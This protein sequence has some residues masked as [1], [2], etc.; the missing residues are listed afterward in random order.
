MDDPINASQAGW[1]REI[2]EITS[3]RQ[4]NEGRGGLF[5]SINS[6]RIMIS[7]RGTGGEGNRSD[8]R[9]AESFPYKENCGYIYK[10]T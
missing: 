8:S 10:S 4:F 5:L 6:T 1:E 3:D 9:S 7:L 2:Y